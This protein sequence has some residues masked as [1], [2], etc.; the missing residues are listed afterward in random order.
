MTKFD[1]AKTDLTAAVSASKTFLQAQDAAPTLATTFAALDAIKKSLDE[2]TNGEL[3]LAV[4]VAST[5]GDLETAFKIERVTAL[6]RQRARMEVH[7][8]ELRAVVG[9]VAVEA[10]RP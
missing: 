10:R 9:E 7:L 6:R 1:D 4:L 2:W 8:G 5:D 3:S